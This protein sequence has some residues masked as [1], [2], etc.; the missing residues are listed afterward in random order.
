MQATLSKKLKQSVHG[1][2]V[3]ILLWKL[4]QLNVETGAD[5][6]IRQM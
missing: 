6:E 5:T 4:E 1:K 3:S 2:Y